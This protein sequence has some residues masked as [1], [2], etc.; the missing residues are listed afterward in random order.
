M[1]I[2]PSAIGFVL[3]PSVSSSNKKD[4]AALTAS[5]CRHSFFLTSILCIGTA[6]FGKYA[7][8]IVYGKVF[9]PSYLPVLILLPGV[10]IISTATLTSSYLNGIGKVIYSPII[11][12]TMLVINITLNIILIPAYGILGAAIASSICYSYGGLLGVFFFL[13]NSDISLK[14]VYIMKKD[15]FLFYIR[16][17][18]GH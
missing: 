18:K 13:K 9:L 2:I 6:F 5:T 3:F 15:D 16:K 10:L 7:I 8:E 4:A 1:W 14:D 11:T 17:I 12:S